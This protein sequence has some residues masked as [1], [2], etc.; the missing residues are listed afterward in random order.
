MVG[1]IVIRFVGAI[2]GIWEEGAKEIDGMAVGY[3]VGI[4]VGDNVVGVI[5]G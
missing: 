3:L 4:T 1:A 5:V 2:V